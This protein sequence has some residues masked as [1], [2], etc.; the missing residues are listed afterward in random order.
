MRALLLLL[1]ILILPPSPVCEA[2]GPVPRL[3]GFWSGWAER[4]GIRSNVSVRLFSR[5]GELAG[6]VDW[7]DM[8]YY[9]LD[10]IGVRIEGNETAISVPLPV[11]ALKLIGTVK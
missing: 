2:A 11:G 3:A 7:P 8:G 1:A 6:T 9:R 5:N 10:L 4:D